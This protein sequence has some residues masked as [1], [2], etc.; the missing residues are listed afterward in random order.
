MFAEALPPTWWAGALL[1]VVG[2]VLI[3]R[4]DE[5]EGT[6]DGR[7]YQTVPG[8]EEEEEELRPSEGNASVADSE[9]DE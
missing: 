4:R 2:N 1:L 6:K 8:S 5:L 9:S 7:G 3:G